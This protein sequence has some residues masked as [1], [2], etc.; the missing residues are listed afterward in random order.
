VG[1][2]LAAAAVCALLAGCASTVAGRG[3][4]VA[5]ASSG[6]A[7]GSPTATATGPRLPNLPLP[8]GGGADPDPEVPDSPCDVLDAGELKAQFGQDADIDREVDSCKITA[9]DGTF[10]SFNAYAS[11]TLSYE[12]K[13]EEGRPLTIAGQPAYIAQNDHYIVVGRSKS[14][15]DRGILTCYVGFSGS[16]QINGIQLATRLFEELM[17]HYVY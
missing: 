12:E 13:H 10:L 2:A 7:P 3:Q 15:D 11:L 16:S 9:A 6:P 4:P 5:A 8:P 1:A 17:P 14:P